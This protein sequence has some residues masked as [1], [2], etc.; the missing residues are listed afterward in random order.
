ML[1][2]NFQETGMVDLHEPE[3]KF[4]LESLGGLVNKMKRKIEKK[5]NIDKQN[6]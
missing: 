2:N 6:C 5:E 3:T 4:N 1:I